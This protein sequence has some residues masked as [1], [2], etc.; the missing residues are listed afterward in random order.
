[1]NPNKLVNGHYELTKEK[2]ESINSRFSQHTPLPTQ[3]ERYSQVRQSA[4][5]MAEMIHQCVPDSREQ[6]I[7][8]TKIGRAHV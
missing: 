6:S 1:M 7:A 3:P 4:K 5:K 2:N 8:P